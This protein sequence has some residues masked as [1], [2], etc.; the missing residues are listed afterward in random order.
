M[1]KKRVKMAITKEDTGY[2]AN[3][4]LGN[5]FVGTQGESLDELK[6]NILDALKVTFPKTAFD[7]RY[8]YDLESFFNF[9]AVINAKALSERI[10]MNQSLLAPSAFKGIK[11]P[12]PNQT[13]RIL[14]G[15]QEVG[16]ELAKIELLV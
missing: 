16:R 14:A 15:V 9:Y 6:K 13:R 1:K 5:H 3:A 8:A 2:S 11:T 4:I 12:S 10:G 7:V